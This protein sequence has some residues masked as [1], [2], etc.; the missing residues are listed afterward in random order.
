M[1]SIKPELANAGAD[2]EGWHAA[3]TCIPLTLVEIRRID[4][5]RQQAGGD[6]ARW[7]AADPRSLH[8][9][10]RFQSVN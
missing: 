5:K 7:R 4:S 2:E 6:R 10:R 1:S 9:R 8:H 3:S